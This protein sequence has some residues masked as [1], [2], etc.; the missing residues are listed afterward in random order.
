MLNCTTSQFSVIL[1]ELQEFQ[2]LIKA[3]V[4]NIPLMW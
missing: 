4:P 2:H 1:S 3:N